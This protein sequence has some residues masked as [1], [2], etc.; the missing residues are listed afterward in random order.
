MTN[1]SKKITPS[2]WSI[3][4]KRLIVDSEDKPIAYFYPRDYESDIANAKLMA[5]SPDLLAACEL[6]LEAE[7][8]AANGNGR[9]GFGLYCDGIEAA[10]AAVAKA[11][12]EP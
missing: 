7:L 2:P 12:G 5:A 4:E 9:T 6:F 3:S 1:N 8:L 10:K 11:R